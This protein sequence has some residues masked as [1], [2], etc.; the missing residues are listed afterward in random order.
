M[1]NLTEQR[2]NNSI[3]SEDMIFLDALSAEE[4]AYIYNKEPELQS[5]VNGISPQPY[6]YI[7]YA[8]SVELYFTGPY[9]AS[10]SLFYVGVIHQ[11]VAIAC[12]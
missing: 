2:D 6:Y 5:I 8:A 10:L 4:L 7:G 9:L 11:V 1:T 3:A 12:H